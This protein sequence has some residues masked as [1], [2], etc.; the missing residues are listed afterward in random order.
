[1]TLSTTR[2]SKDADP[3]IVS[4][5]NFGL[6]MEA[7]ARPGT[8]IDVPEGYG[9]VGKMNAGSATIAK[10][11]CD[12]ETPVWL[13]TDLSS[14]SVQDFLRFQCACPITSEKKSAQFAFFYQCPDE[15]FLN[16]FA[17]GSPAY[18]DASTTLIIQIDKLQEG[19]AVTLSGPGIKSSHGLHVEEVGNNFWKWWQ[20]NNSRFPLGLDVFLATCNHLAA[21]PRT[22][23]VLEVV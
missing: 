16:D 13:D 15:E 23:K 12:H 11:L 2:L 5:D 14:E 8:I 10:T 4:A 22:V 21:L 3:A 6:L 18:P 17:I 1:M 19:N 9:A 20:I 7:M